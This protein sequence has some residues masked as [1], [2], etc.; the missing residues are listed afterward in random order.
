MIWRSKTEE[1]PD[2]SKKET[3]VGEVFFDVSW[4]LVRRL[5][6]GTSELNTVSKP[7]LLS[8]DGTASIRTTA[9]SKDGKYFAYGISRSVGALLR[10]PELRPSSFA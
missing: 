7:N 6:S 9:T 8:E 4:N 10:H 5:S 1:L 3:E 2:F